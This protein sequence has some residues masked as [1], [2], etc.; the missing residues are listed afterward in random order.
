MSANLF[1]ENKLNKKE[2]KGLFAIINHNQGNGYNESNSLFGNSDNQTI[3]YNDN[4]QG[5]SLF[6][7]NANNN[8]NQV[9]GLLKDNQKEKLFCNNLNHKNVNQG[10]TLFENCSNNKDECFFGN[11]NQSDKG[12]FNINT[13]NNNSNNYTLFDNW[14]NNN[15]KLFENII[16]NNTENS[17][18]GNEGD[19]N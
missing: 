12:L 10:K 11:T 5:K 2:D 17:F 16:N 7:N 13:N 6:I 14:N 1:D 9:G 4:N 18:F 3:E 19:I 15:S 8:I